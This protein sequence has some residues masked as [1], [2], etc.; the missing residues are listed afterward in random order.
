MVQLALMLFHINVLVPLQSIPENVFIIASCNPHRGD[1]FAAIKDQE[2]WL[3]ATYHVRKLHPT[4][5]SLLWDYG[6]LNEQQ[7]REYVNVKMKMLTQQSTEGATDFRVFSKDIAS[8]TDLI[9]QS[10][11]KVREYAYEQLSSVNIPKHEAR[12]CAKSS[13]SLRD[14]ERV[15]TFYKWLLKIYIQFNPH[16]ELTELYHRRAIMVSLG[17]VYFMRLDSKYRSKYR[18]FLDH[19]HFDLFYKVTFSEA[20]ESELRWYIDRIELPRSIAK[21]EALKENV[22]ATVAC[23][24][25]HTPLI[26]VGDPGSSKTLSVNIVIANF[27]G[28]QSRSL[29]FRNTDVFKSLDA[30]FYQCS[31]KTT[32]NEIETIFRRAITRQRSLQ[33]IPL[34]VHCVVFMDEAGL[35]EDKLESLKVLHYYLDRPEVSFVAISNHVLDAAKTNRAVSIFRPKATDQ[36]LYELAKGT[37]LPPGQNE[38]SEDEGNLL[39]KLCFSYNRVLLDHDFQQLFGLRDFIHFVAYLRRKRRR[40]LD[41]QLILEGLER[42][43]NGSK[44]FHDLFK[45]FFE[46]V[47]FLTL[48]VLS[49]LGGGYATRG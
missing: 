19:N 48:Y 43:F 4:L 37:I 17:I 47:S 31:R 25:T 34:P 22:F 5:Q 2:S 7:E 41:E 23:T 38:P 10:Q 30:H 1:L 42:N 32:S 14:I 36:E 24:M 16:E 35:P 33:N 13:V 39:R 15:F 46:K 3:K 49:W 28:S 44:K 26:I 11:Q 21:T 18:L 29:A 45:L 9:L 8:L 40:Y 12:V 6:S 20:F 27:K